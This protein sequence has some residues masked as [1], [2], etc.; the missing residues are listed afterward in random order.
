MSG[1]TSCQ[2]AEADS[3]LDCGLRG[4]AWW[5]PRGPSR[6]LAQVVGCGGRGVA[7]G[8]GGGQG[9]LER[10]DFT[11]DATRQSVAREPIRSGLVMGGCSVV[12]GCSLVGTGV[13]DGL[14][15][16]PYLEELRVQGD[17]LRFWPAWSCVG[18][19]VGLG[20]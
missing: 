2:K 6:M 14:L 7:C 10:R 3:F 12:C 13:S 4:V 1:G 8:S 5:L 18:V 15:V 20:T 17:L 16:S 19:A 11:R 9:R